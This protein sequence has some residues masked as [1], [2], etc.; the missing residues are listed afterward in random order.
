MHKLNSKTFNI[1]FDQLSFDDS[2][3]FIKSKLSPLESLLNDDDRYESRA[4]RHFIHY[5][6]EMK[7]IDYSG[8][9]G[10]YK[11]IKEIFGLNPGTYI[12]LKSS[13][14][15]H[16]D[17]TYAQENEVETVKK[18]RRNDFIRNNRLIEDEECSDNNVTS[19]AI[20][21]L[22]LILMIFKQKFMV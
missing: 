9:G 3:G 5:L 11:V 7:I 13:D 4:L 6:S 8:G 16:I 21:T 17:I 1:L 12:R 22:I 18:E 20:M 15:V 14:E 2:I 10:D 19:I